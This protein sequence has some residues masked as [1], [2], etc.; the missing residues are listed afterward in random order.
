M[1][2]LKYFAEKYEITVLDNNRRHQRYQPT[3]FYPQDE[4]AQNYMGSFDTEALY[5]ITIPEGQLNT[6]VNM[7]S[8]LMKFRDGKPYGD[9]AE[10]LLDNEREEVQLRQSSPAIAKAYSEYVLLLHLSGMSSKF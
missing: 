4:F 6:L 9:L 5:T 10:T 7:E 1:N 2:N 3:M 8:R